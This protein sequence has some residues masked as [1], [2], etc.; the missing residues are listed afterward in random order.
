M[1]ICGN[2]ALSDDKFLRVTPLFSRFHA[3]STPTSGTTAACHCFLAKPCF[4]LSEIGRD[5]HPKLWRRTKSIVVRAVLFAHEFNE[6]APLTPC[7]PPGACGD[8]TKS[9]CTCPTGGALL[10]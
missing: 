3:F 1:I 9:Q 8:L 2:E 10:W 7:E 6:V 4:S 5:S